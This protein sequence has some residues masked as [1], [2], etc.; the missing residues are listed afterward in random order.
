MTLFSMCSFSSF[1]LTVISLSG[2]GRV[3]E[4]IQSAYWQRQG[5]PWESLA[6]PGPYMSIWGFVALLK[7]TFAILCW[8]PGT[9]H[10]HQKS[11]HALSILWVELRTLCF[12][13][14]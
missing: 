10:Y 9:F 13:T 1:F 11:F 7:S 8:C 3:L 2:H 14:A 4:P 6:Y 5:K 12:S